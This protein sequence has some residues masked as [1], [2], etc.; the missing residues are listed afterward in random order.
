M[1]TLR[2]LHGEFIGRPSRLL[3][4]KMELVE[5]SRAASAPS[6]AEAAGRRRAAAARATARQAIL[7]R[8]KT[9]RRI[10]ILKRGAT[11]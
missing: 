10:F 2:L 1:R 9:L 6:R 8:A 3:S 4:P 7:F 11:P 5:A